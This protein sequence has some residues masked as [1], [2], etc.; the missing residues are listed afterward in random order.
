MDRIFRA[1]HWMASASDLLS[2]LALSLALTSEYLL[3]VY[4]LQYCVQTSLMEFS[5]V[6]THTWTACFNQCIRTYDNVVCF[7]F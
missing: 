5:L 3:C 4:T 2:N 7:P 6:Y 1:W